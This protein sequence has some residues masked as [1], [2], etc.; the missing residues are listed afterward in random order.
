[1]LDY[2]NVHYAEDHLVHQFDKEIDNVNYFITK[3]FDETHFYKKIVVEDEALEEP[4][5]YTEKVAKFLTGRFYR[6]VCLPG[7]ANPGGFWRL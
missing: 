1:V 7:I 5:V 6:D 3:W 4:L 2:L